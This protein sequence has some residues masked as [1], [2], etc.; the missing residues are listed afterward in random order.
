LLG[1]K[2][3]TLLGSCPGWCDLKML[4][5]YFG[6]IIF[7]YYVYFFQRNIPWNH[8]IVIIIYHL[9]HFST[10][11]G[12]FLIYTNGENSSGWV[13]WLCGLKTHITK[14]NFLF[15]YCSKRFLFSCLI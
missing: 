3:R 6:V 9:T 2:P 11:D 4:K 7:L 10:R 5:H 14:I 12:W 13:S 1:H 8:Y 15:V